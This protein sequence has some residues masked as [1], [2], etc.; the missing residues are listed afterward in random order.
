MSDYKFICPH[1]NQSLEAPTDMLGQTIECPTCNRAI[2]LPP[3][4]PAISTG[5][6]VPKIKLSSSAINQKIENNC[7]LCGKS[8]HMPKAKS[9]YG[10]LVCKKCYYSFANRRQ[11][12]FAIDVILWNIFFVI[13]AAFIVGVQT[14]EQ[15]SSLWFACL[16]VFFFKD[17]FSGS[18]P[19]KFV[20]GIKAINE[21]SGKPVRFGSS[22]KR[23]LPLIIPFMPIAVAYQLCK[24]HRTG[25]KWSESKVIWKKYANNPVFLP[26]SS[27]DY[28]ATPIELEEQASDAL[29]QATRLEAR[30]HIPEAL[31][32]YEGIIAIYSTT[33]TA[34]D[35]QISL[36]SLKKRM[37]T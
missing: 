24:G 36:D 20:M 1:C 3:P 32:A 2:E 14:E 28:Q 18:S 29:A 11:L 4:P 7:P 19:G 6:H 26:K 35:A 16:L 34:R 13:F 30:G 9:L 33:A 37:S 27:A 5:A 22:F 10:H 15:E 8:K 12:A 31:K 21:I 17:G 23:N 25:D